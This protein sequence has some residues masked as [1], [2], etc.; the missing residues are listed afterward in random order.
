MAADPPY[1]S[2]HYDGGLNIAN[3]WYFSPLSWTPSFV[4]D[5][6]SGQAVRVTDCAATAPG[7]CVDGS[8]SSRYGQLVGV[9]ST[10]QTAQCVQIHAGYSTGDCS[11]STAVGKLGDDTWYHYHVRFPAG[12]QAT[13]G[14]QNTTFEVHVDRG[15]EADATGGNI[16]SNAVG[17][18]A[19]GDPA[20]L[21]PG[22]PNFCTTAGT[23]PHLFLQVTGGQTAWP[24]YGSPGQAHRYTDPNALL[25]GHWYDVLLHYTFSP[26]P[27]VGH[28]QW[29]VDGTLEVDVTVPTQYQRRN[30][31]L[32]Y[33]EDVG[34]YNYRYWASWASSVDY[35]ELVSGPTRASVGG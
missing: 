12:Y 11:T 25:L 3:F 34:T 31:S 27:L 13:P 23:N 17:V 7:Q 30:G 18:A 33:G 32:G 14:T 19:D 16:G 20:V 6:V 22:S 10:V 9:E 29:W 2:E 5:G 26:D 4:M 24:L 35:D 8:S 28:V 15:S 1:L 21:C